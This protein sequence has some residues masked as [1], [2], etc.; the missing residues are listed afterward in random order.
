[1]HRASIR[2][3]SRGLGVPTAVGRVPCELRLARRSS[4]QA[5]DVVVNLCNQSLYLHIQQ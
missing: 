4:G 1:M 5:R 3:G 2:D